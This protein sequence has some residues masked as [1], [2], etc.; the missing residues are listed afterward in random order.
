MY[1]GGSL[2]DVVHLAHLVHEDEGVYLMV[3][4]AQF[5]EVVQ[6]RLGKHLRVICGHSFKKIGDPDVVNLP[7]DEECGL[8]FGRVVYP[9]VR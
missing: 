7:E 4:Q 9:P 8:A 3:P 6:H 2:E 1:W 5:L